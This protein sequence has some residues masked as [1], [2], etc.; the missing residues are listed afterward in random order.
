MAENLVASLD[1]TPADSTRKI[2]R[3]VTGLDGSLQSVI[4]IDDV[5]P[6]VTCEAGSDQFIVTQ[7]AGRCR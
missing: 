6:H 7:L 2:R 3:V 4:A 5:S 1:L